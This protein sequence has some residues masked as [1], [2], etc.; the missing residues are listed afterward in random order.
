MLYPWPSA[1][2]AVLIRNHRTGK[3]GSLLDDRPS[4]NEKVG[5]IGIARR[6]WT[7]LREFPIA[8]GARRAGAIDERSAR[9]EIPG[10]FEGFGFR[11]AGNRGENPISR[12]KNARVSR[13]AV[14]IERLIATRRGLTTDGTDHTDIDAGSSRCNQFLTHALR[15][16]H[17]CHRCHPWFS[18]WGSAVGMVEQEHIAKAAGCRFYSEN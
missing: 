12:I 13:G 5:A 11:L 6:D 1:K 2:S 16:S 3:L 7:I 18:C 8:P 4:G 15:P 9:L 10:R 17:P 14:V